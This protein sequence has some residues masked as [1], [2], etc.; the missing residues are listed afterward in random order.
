MALGAVTADAGSEQ[1]RFDGRSACEL[2]A[3]GNRTIRIR[4]LDDNKTRV[5][6][7]RVLLEAA[8]IVAAMPV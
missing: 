1:T 3:S 6:E 2:G 5:L 4:K 8:R 7:L